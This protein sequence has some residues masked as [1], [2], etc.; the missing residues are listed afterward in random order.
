M[1]KLPTIPGQACVLR[2]GAGAR[3]DGGDEAA[4]AA[5]REAAGEQRVAGG[6]RPG[7][8]LGG[9][10][11][12]RWEEDAARWWCWGLKGARSEDGRSDSSSGQRWWQ[13]ARGPSR[14]ER[15]LGADGLRPRLAHGPPVL[16][17]CRGRNARKRLPKPCA[18]LRERE[19]PAGGG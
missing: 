10:M 17:A 9:G 19:E 13:V 18:A 1:R 4:R 14:R 11:G 12:R 5:A 7:G 8:G 15:T 6:C 2:R 16:R 3:D